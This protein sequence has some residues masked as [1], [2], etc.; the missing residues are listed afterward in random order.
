M[1]ALM[2]SFLLLILFSCEKQPERTG[3]KSCTTSVLE[4]DLKTGQGIWKQRP[5]WGS[6]YDLCDSALLRK[7]DGQI[8]TMQNDSI[9]TIYVTNC[10][11]IRPWN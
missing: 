8:W 5:D 2:I 9:M 1:K 3:C 6:R 7:F 4:V 10:E 11:E